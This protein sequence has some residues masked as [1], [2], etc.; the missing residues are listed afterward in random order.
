MLAE[1]AQ[2]ADQ[3]TTALE[4][5]DHTRAIELT[6]TLFWTFCDDYLELVKARAYD[7]DGEI[8]AQ[9]GGAA[10]VASAR[11]TLNITIDTSVLPYAAEEVWSWYRTGSV[12]RAAW[13][14]AKDFEVDT[15]AHVLRAA[16]AALIALRKVKT[17]QKVAQRSEYLH[18]T[19]TVPSK[20]LKATQ[21]VIRDLAATSNVSG[22][23]TLLE[24][25]VDAPIVTDFELKA[26]Q[27]R[28]K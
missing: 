27:P 14:S 16:S 15:D 10:K 12:H 5:Y 4:N 6:E 8:S 23:F 22:E 2:V 18:V 1:L 21:A 7:R 20:D 3:A 25:D 28:K 26:A 13:P 24:A 9:E 19:L 11:A 17:E